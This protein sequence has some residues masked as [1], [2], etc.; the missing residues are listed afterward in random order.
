[1]ID[2]L[3]FAIVLLAFGFVTVWFA[4]ARRKA[5]VTVT[6]KCGRRNITAVLID[7][8]SRACAEAILTEACFWCAPNRDSEHGAATVRERTCGTHGAATVRERTCGT[9]GAAGR[10]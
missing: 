1:M 9:H 8:G 5:T 3:I 6:C 10:S 7:S 2:V 4:E